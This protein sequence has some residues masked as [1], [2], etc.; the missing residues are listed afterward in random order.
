M[1]RPADSAPLAPFSRFAQQTIDLVTGHMPTTAIDVWTGS[2]YNGTAQHT[3]PVP[4]SLA[5]YSRYQRDAGGHVSMFTQA[6]AGFDNG[7]A[8]NL[9][10]PDGT[11]VFMTPR[12]LHYV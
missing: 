10:L 12:Y 7:T 8:T 11:P 2:E 6:P 9:W 5:N 4:V 1:P 3:I